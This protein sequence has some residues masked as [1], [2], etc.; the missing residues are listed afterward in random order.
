[1]NQ[2]QTV[3]EQPIDSPCLPNGFLAAAA[4][5][6]FRPQQP[7]RLDLALLYSERPATAAGVFTQN[8]FCAAPVKL[9]RRSLYRE[10][11]LQALLCNSGQANAGTGP[12]GEEL[13]LWEQQQLQQK[14]QLAHLHY[15]AVLS[16]G[17]IGVLPPKPNIAKGLEKIQLSPQNCSLGTFADGAA[18]FSRAI[19]TTDT[20][21]KTSAYRLELDG[22]EVCIAGCAKGSGMIHPNMATMLAFITTDAAVEPV[23]LQELLRNSTERSFNRI[24]VDGD[25][26]T[27][28]SVLIFANGLAKNRP[29]TPEHPEWQKF[30]RALER[31]CQ[32]LA[33][34]IVRDGEGATKFIE[35]EV[36][37]AP[38]ERDAALC[39][40][41]KGAGAASTA[42]LAL[43][44]RSHYCCFSSQILADILFS[45]KGA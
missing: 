16:T 44:L 41:A 1:M 24:S 7:E 27:N 30:Q 28:D 38:T 10:H 5:A 25:C 20:K 23:L 11:K 18:D 31:L 12:E 15:G 21:T 13:A 6:N 37:G 19:L 34:A 9:T 3:T 32:D 2:T 26:S 45:I 42:P 39:A 36:C 33:K 8:R 29:I 40:L 35:I 22:K 4:A 43:F 17:V 14:L